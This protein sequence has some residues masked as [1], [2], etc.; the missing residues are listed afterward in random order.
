MDARLPLNSPQMDTEQPAQT[1]RVWDLPL[2]LFHWVM[3]AVVVVAGVTGFLAPEWWLGLHVIAGYALATLLSFRLVWGF[4]GTRYSRFGS[5]PLALGG[6]YEHLRSIVRTNPKTVIGHNPAGAW[7]II[8]LLVA[9][10]T[11]VV[12]GLIALGGQENHGPLAAATGFLAGEMAGEIHQIAAW[13]LAAAVAVHLLGVFA[14]TRIFRHP[15][16]AAMMIG[17]K[18]P[19]GSAVNVPR[20]A[21]TVRG[22][23]WFMAIA[24]ALL[25]SGITLAGLPSSG[26]RA[27]DTPAVYVSECGDCHAVYHPSLRTGE[28]WRSM[29]NGL[30]NHY[31]E[32]ASLDE[33]TVSI[34]QA[35]LVDNHAGTF[36]TEAAQR[37]G[38]VE[39]P[40]LRMTDV[41]YWKSR[42][43][44]I[45]ESVFRLNSVG[46]K[47]NC[48]ACHTDAASGR[49]DD[50]KIHLPEKDKP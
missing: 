3:A 14:E 20:S 39:T 6:L 18:A 1:A 49:F 40:S 13:G 19:P 23:A 22:A 10:V 31:G 44:G 33:Q 34:I 28:A 47:V 11:L 24:G 8:I 38:R 25:V 2:R 48:T 45:A 21:H 42:H 30:E 27:L 50:V 46:S 29:M 7:M 37:I 41:A 43:Q 35:Y 26:W 4:V 32:D 15:V 17:R 5:F 36:D 16:V 9:L 12:S